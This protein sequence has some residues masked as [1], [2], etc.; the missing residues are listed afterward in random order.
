MEEAQELKVFRFGALI[1]S[2]GS[3]P[4]L[5]SIHMCCTE[6]SQSLLHFLLYIDSNESAFLKANWPVEPP[7]KKCKHF[8]SV[9]VLMTFPCF[10]KTA[11]KKAEKNKKSLKTP[12]SISEGEGQYSSIKEGEWRIDVTLT[13]C[14]K[15]HDLIKNSSSL[16]CAGIISPLSQEP[17]G[18]G[19]KK[20]NKLSQRCQIFWKRGGLSESIFSLRGK[21]VNIEWSSETELSHRGTEVLF[22]YEALC[23]VSMDHSIFV[24]LKLGCLSRIPVRS[25][26]D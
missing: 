22:V 16:P 10:V 15:I 4:N 5:E 6:S 21:A 9:P 8:M 23:L 13:C 19:Q 7:F 11:N 1:L 25:V 17:L 26:T 3:L 20:G 14:G 24:K 18:W 2:L 12:N